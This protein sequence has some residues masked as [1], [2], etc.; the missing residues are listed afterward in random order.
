[1]ITDRIWPLFRE[2][3]TIRFSLLI[4]LLLGI[5]LLLLGI[6]LPC[7]YAQDLYVISDRTIA[8]GTPINGTYDTVRIGRDSSA[9]NYNGVHADII[10][11]LYNNDLFSFNT[12]TLNITGGKVKSWMQFTSRFKPV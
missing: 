5:S 12:S 9:V 2:G 7:V 11:G 8:N 10:G 6:S 4:P 1:M 3:R